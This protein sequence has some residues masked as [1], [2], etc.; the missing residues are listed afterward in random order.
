MSRKAKAAS[1]KK[2]APSKAKKGEADKTTEFSRTTAGAAL[3]L[4]EM[5]DEAEAKVEE[6][7]PR[8]GEVKGT[9]AK[10]AKLLR[11][12]AKDKDIDDKDRGKLFVR[13]E[14]NMLRREVELKDLVDQNAGQVEMKKS[15]MADLRQ[16]IR[17][18]AD[19]GLLFEKGEEKPAADPTAGPASSNSTG[20]TANG[21]STPSSPAPGEYVPNPA[22][23]VQLSSIPMSGGDRDVLAA[24]GIH[25]LDDV[26]M[27]HHQNPGSTIV[28]VLPD[29][30]Q[31]TVVTIGERIKEIIKPRRRRKPEPEVAAA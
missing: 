11:D 8:I 16:L 18:K 28:D 25:S 10:D 17:D 1:K 19:G 29:V 5:Y 30:C 2:P 31:G 3:A 20:S 13:T 27:L 14:T 6:L 22:L 15:S 21:P 26:A 4:V 7:K 12:L 23:N 24:R 9:L